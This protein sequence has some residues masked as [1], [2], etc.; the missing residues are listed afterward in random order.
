[1]FICLENLQR[2]DN[3]KNEKKIE[4]GNSKPPLEPLG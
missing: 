1:L 3:Y 4:W 2:G